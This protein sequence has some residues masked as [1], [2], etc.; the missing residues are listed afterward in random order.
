MLADLQK[1]TSVA[2]FSFIIPYSFSRDSHVRDSQHHGWMMHESNRGKREIS[3]FDEEL[4]KKRGEMGGFKN[5]ALLNLPG[6]FIMPVI[7]TSIDC[8]FEIDM[9]NS[10]PRAVYE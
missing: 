2:G 9:S 3:L 4:E 6:V 8:E 10:S 7:V 5:R 1:G